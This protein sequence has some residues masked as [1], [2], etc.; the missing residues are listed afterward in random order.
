MFYKEQEVIQRMHVHKE[1]VM[2]V[3]VS[4]LHAS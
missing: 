3:K 4:A 1:H 2:N